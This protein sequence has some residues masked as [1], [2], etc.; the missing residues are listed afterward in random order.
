MSSEQLSMSSILANLR[1][2]EWYFQ[3][4]IH[5]TQSNTVSLSCISF[6]VEEARHQILSMVTK[7]EQLAKEK[8]N[9]EKEKN[10][11]VK[12]SSGAELFAH[13]LSHYKK[14]QEMYQCNI[15]IDNSIRDS[16]MDPRD[17]TLNMNVVYQ[18]KQFKLDDMIKTV[19][20]TIKP[21]NLISFN[22]IY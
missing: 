9:L 10:Q 5:Y 19:D 2:F 22:V 20:P 11:R 6:S 12:Y 17:Y 7:F 18:D 14:M 13:E 15:H 21:A 4:P 8:N 3:I 1:L 16:A